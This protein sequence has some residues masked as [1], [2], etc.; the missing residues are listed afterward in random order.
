[1]IDKSIVSK[2]EILKIKLFTND[3]KSTF[4]DKEEL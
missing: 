4:F 3:E 2:K 1:M